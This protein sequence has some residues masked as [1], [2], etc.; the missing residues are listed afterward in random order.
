MTRQVVHPIL[1]SP[2]LCGAYSFPPPSAAN[3]PLSKAPPPNLNYENSHSNSHP[4]HPDSFSP[5]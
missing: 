5:P 2:T 1:S 3:P 4:S